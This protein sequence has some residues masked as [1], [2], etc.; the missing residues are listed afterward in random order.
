MVPTKC[1][2]VNSIC[3]IKLMPPTIWMFSKLDDSKCETEGSS[4]G[5]KPMPSL[6]V[7][8]ARGRQSWIFPRGEPGGLPPSSTGYCVE[9][10]NG[11]SEPHSEVATVWLSVF[12]PSATT[13]RL[14]VLQEVLMW[15]S[16]LPPWSRENL[17]QM[18]IFMSTAEFDTSKRFGRVKKCWFLFIENLTDCRRHGPLAPCFWAREDPLSNPFPWG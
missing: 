9:R 11:S 12:W 18:R 16:S 4:P 2:E 13:N 17:F 8:N 5:K 1:W 6:E 10:M 14:G 7:G 3:E 15:P